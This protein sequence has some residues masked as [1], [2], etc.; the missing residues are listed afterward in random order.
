MSSALK[1]I[2]AYLA[3]FVPIGYICYYAYLSPDDW[4]YL[5]GGQWQGHYHGAPG[6]IAG[7]GLPILMIVGVGYWAIR[8]Y[9]RK[10]S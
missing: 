6:P 5:G 2:L 4:T 8:R 9:R 3:T 7:A 1:A 10:G